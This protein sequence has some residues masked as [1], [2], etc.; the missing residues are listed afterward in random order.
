MWSTIDGQNQVKQSV[1][2]EQTFQNQTQELLTPCQHRGVSPRSP[3][4]PHERSA[5]AESNQQ[6]QSDKCKTLKW[7]DYK[8]V[9][10]QNK[11]GE[12]QCKSS[13]S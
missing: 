11:W 5:R 6:K 1:L 10:M 13:A 7:R 8:N 9:F 2:W 4:R 3:I 12:A